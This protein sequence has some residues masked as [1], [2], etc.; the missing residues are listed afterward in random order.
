MLVDRAARTIA[1]L[2]TPYGPVGRAGRRRWQF[3]Q[4]WADPA[5]LVRL[6]LDHDRAQ[7]RGVVVDHVDRPDGLWVRIRVD[8]TQA[9]D[10]AL[11]LAGEAGYGL[12]VGIDDPMD[13]ACLGGAQVVRRARWV[14]VSLT[15]TPA[16]ESEA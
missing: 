3:E 4:G 7:R 10:Q 15:A 6:L 9:G 2:A 12:S 13:V 5:P 14:E 11:W 16:F 8:R 1:G